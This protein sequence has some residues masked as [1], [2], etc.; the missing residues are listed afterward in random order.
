MTDRQHRKDRYHAV[1]RT[2]AANTTEV[3]PPGIR[4]AHIKVHLV[5]NGRYTAEGVDSAI[6]AA[7]EH[8]DLVKWTDGEGRTRYTL[9]T[10]ADL[11]RVAER[12]HDQGRQSDLSRI[13][14]KIE[15]VRQDG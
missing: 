7:V 4:P 13:N 6:R 3:Q 14:R 11:R 2:V 8:D 9:A 1:L 15:E 10:T 12:L 5:S